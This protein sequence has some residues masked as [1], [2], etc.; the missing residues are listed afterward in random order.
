MSRGKLIDERT[1][2]LEGAKQP[3]IEAV[4]TDLERDEDNI[5]TVDSSEE[6]QTKDTMEAVYD[7]DSNTIAITLKTGEELTIREPKGKDFLEAEAWIGSVDESRQSPTF[8]V[9]R[10]A[11][12]C[13]TF[14]K[15][16]KIIPKPKMEDFLDLLDDYESIE[17][18]QRAI[19]FFRISIEKYFERLEARIKELGLDMPK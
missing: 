19:G 17:K 10:V 7:E 1:H 9:L 2:R 6:E 15:E 13:S 12:T 3:T 11:L 8:L 14:R 4:A 16:G 5:L 18:V